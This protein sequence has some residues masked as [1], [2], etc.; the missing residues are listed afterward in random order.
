MKP[1]QPPPF[2]RRI[3]ARRRRELADRIA[4]EQ[5]DLMLDGWRRAR[6]VPGMAGLLDDLR[7][8]HARETGRPH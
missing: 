6:A 7:A 3:R 1:R 8:M 2:M 5:C 4:R